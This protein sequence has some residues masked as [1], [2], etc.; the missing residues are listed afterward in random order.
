MTPE[1]KRGIIIAI[2]EFLVNSP[3]LVLGA[4]PFLGKLRV[5][6]RTLWITI[7]AISIFN[8]FSYFYLR[9][10]HYGDNYWVLTMA[11]YVVYYLLIVIFFVR[12]FDLYWAQL[13]YVFLF[14]QAVSSL[15]NT[16]SL[17]INQL[18]LGPDVTISFANTPSY[19]LLI[20]IM[21]CIA[22]PPVLWLFKHRLV[23]AFSQLGKRDLIVLCI[24]PLLF[25]ITFEVTLSL[26]NTYSSMMYVYILTMI[27]G[28]ATYVINLRLV[29]T[30]AQGA[31]LRA[32]RREMINLIALQ[33]E[34]YERLTDRVEQSRAIRH[35]LRFHF[36]TL[37]GLANQ[38]DMPAILSYL[39]KHGTFTTSHEEVFCENHAVD[40]IVGHFIG[41]A[42]ELG[43]EV[44]AKLSLPTNAGIPDY[45]LCVVFGNLLENAVIALKK[46]IGERRLFV[47][48]EKI[49]NQ[50][51]IVVDNTIDEAQAKF[52]K[53]IGIRSVT[54]IAEKYGSVPQ[55]MAQDGMFRVS[56]ILYIPNAQ[57]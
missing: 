48:A 45:E 25:F 51:L 39:Q 30:S 1:M 4:I 42:E 46:Q 10:F 11:S 8:A 7:L 23:L 19:P 41:Q 17:L 56:V 9:A 2:W 54:A 6:K 32:E 34:K 28:I 31:T 47:R 44:D 37:A 55:I 21:N 50:V 43:V 40:A 5:K 18:W 26:H 52:E 14:I 3:W 38:N 24:T 22:I 36:S 16:L 49:Q 20:F 27:T 29:L 35:D 57:K 13:V 53:G 15:I 12:Y 33:S